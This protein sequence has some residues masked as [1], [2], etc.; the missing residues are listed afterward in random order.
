MCP[1]LIS[2]G[3]SCVS[4]HRVSQG[5]A[6]SLVPEHSPT[7]L[8]AARGN[9]SRRK[10]IDPKEQWFSEATFRRPLTNRTAIILQLKEGRLWLSCRLSLFATQLQDVLPEVAPSVDRDEHRRHVTP[11]RRGEHHAS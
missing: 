5:S 7:P 1:A 6:A 9:G 4:A 2:S 10:L 8:A 3:A 11:Q